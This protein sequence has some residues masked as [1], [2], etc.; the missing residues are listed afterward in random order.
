MDFVDKP[1]QQSF[2][3]AFD[4]LIQLGAIDPSTGNL[5]KEGERMSVMP[6]EPLY[7]KLLVTALIP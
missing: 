7:S 2:L 6:T 1:S 5:T 3:K 4:I